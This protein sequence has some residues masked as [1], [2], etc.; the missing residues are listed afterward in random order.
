MDYEIPESNV[1]YIP[2]ILKNYT[3]KNVLVRYNDMEIYY[4]VPTD[5]DI[6]KWFETEQLKWI[7]LFRDDSGDDNTI[8]EEGDVIEVDELEPITSN[9]Q[10]E[11][12]LQDGVSLCVVN[13]LLKSDINKKTGLMKKS[14]ILYENK[15][16]NKNVLEMQNKYNNGASIEELEIIADKLNI[17]Y[18]LYSPV[19]LYYPI[20]TI[21]SGI[22]RKF[23]Y[24][25]GHLEYFENTEDLIQEVPELEQDSKLY[26]WYRRD[27]K[28]NINWASTKDKIYQVKST[29]ES[30]DF[31]ARNGFDYISEN[32]DLYNFVHSI[33]T[34]CSPKFLNG[35]TNEKWLDLLENNNVRELDMTNAY[36]KYMEH[37]EYKGHPINFSKLYNVDRIV[38]EGIYIIEPI[39]IS[40]HCEALNEILEK[41]ILTS[42]EIRAYQK[43]LPNTKFKIKKGFWGSHLVQNPFTQ[44]E[45]DNKDYKYI[46]GNLIRTNSKLVYYTKTQSQNCVNRLNSETYTINFHDK[47]SVLTN[48]TKNKTYAHHSIFMISGMNIFTIEQMFKTKMKP[49]RINVDAL[50][51]MNKLPPTDEILPVFREK[52]VRKNKSNKYRNSDKIFKSK[53]INT[54]FSIDYEKEIGPINVLVGK[55]GAGKTHFAVSNSRRPV[56]FVNSDAMA[57]LKHKNKIVAVTHQK[58]A[59]HIKN[60]TTSEKILKYKK[61]VD[62]ATDIIIDEATLL[63]KQQIEDLISLYSKKRI[64]I[65][66]GSGQTKMWSC[67][68]LDISK[69]NQ[70][71]FNY[72]HR[73]KDET[74]RVLTD[75]MY[76]CANKCSGG[77]CCTEMRKYVQDNFKEADA[78]SVSEDSV[79]LARGTT[80]YKQLFSIR[81]IKLKDDIKKT[82]KENNIYSV[83]SIQGDDNTFLMYYIVI[84]HMDCNHLYTAFSR[85]STHEK[86]KYIKL[87]TIELAP[88]KG[89]KKS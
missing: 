51:F 34:T 24:T 79:T 35:M 62:N 72:S 8:F 42:M 63:T 4:N 36:V 75:H 56:L 1:Y 73:I 74:H 17:T 22:E 26:T 78:T 5:V 50:C 27:T 33:R 52:T 76:E 67:E 32:E 13:G 86:C 84:N 11:F 64:Y 85:A 10:P 53:L 55:A 16:Y 12:K 47:V 81:N 54:D 29:Y 44:S 39:Y 41:G 14:T 28:N 23:L 20:I 89:T 83:E 88:I 69:Y 7:W 60:G 80:Q 70:I 9:N 65:L 71:D 66:W 45:I 46:I 77:S 40:T 6:D 30:G 43:L 49:I 61:Y 2:D 37:P 68:L 48:N 87:K 59:D 31:T 82:A 21:G 38:G 58:W 18:V 19:N 15:K 25:D 3:G 57:K